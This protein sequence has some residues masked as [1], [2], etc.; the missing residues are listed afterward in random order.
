MDSGTADKEDRPSL[1]CGEWDVR[2]DRRPDKR[3][4]LTV[5]G[6]CKLP[7]TY[8]AVLEEHEPQDDPE[9]LLLDLE[10]NLPGGARGKV[11]HSESF[12]QLYQERTAVVYVTFRMET[13]TEYKTVTIMDS[14]TG[15]VVAE[16]LKVK[17]IGSH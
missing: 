1:K 12:V 5:S 8:R 3:H 9:V 14:E 10:V 2:H 16:G 15:E 17:P 13:E 4:I 11:E 7:T 6:E